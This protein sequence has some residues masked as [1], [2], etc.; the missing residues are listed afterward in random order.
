VLDG[1]PTVQSNSLQGYLDGALFGSG[2]GSQLWS[3]GDDIGIGQVAEYTKFHTGEASGAPSGLAGLI[4]EVRAYNRALSAAEIE[5][6]SHQSMGTIERL[7]VSLADS[8]IGEQSGSTIATVTRSG[9]T[10]ASL[11]V[12]L[13]SSDSSEATTPTSVTL[14]TGQASATFTIESVDDNVRDGSQAVTITAS[15][16]DM[17]GGCDALIVTDN[18]QLLVRGV[19]ANVTNQWTT[20]ALPQDYM[21]MVVV[22]TPS[23][24]ESSVPLVTRMR[25][26]GSNSF[27][28]RVDRTDGLADP[29]A[30]VSVHY[31]VTEEGVYTQE[32]DGIA[33]EAVKYAST[34]VDGRGNWVGEQRSFAQFYRTPVVLGQVQT[35]NDEAFTQFW[36]R[37]AHQDDPADSQELWVGRHV[38]EDVNVIRSPET[39]G[40]LV[41]EAGTASVDGL[42]F[43]ANVGSATIQGMENS[44]PFQYAING[45]SAA[46]V[47]VANV[48]G[49]YGDQGGWAVLYGADAV[50]ASSLKLAVDEDQAADAERRHVAENVSYLVFQDALLQAVGTPNR[51]AAPAEAT[52]DSLDALLE[53]AIM[54]WG[55]SPTEDHRADQWDLG[56][57]DLPGRQLASFAADRL[58]IDHDAAGHGWFVDDSPTDHAEFFRTFGNHHWVALD[59]GPAAGRVDLLTVLAHELGHADG[60]GHTYHDAQDIMS[61]TLPVG[62]RRLPY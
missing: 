9:D 44:P 61:E 3:H 35:Y 18:E 8:E 51:A 10:T 43:T 23:Y 14:A 11:L 15:A 58:W 49:M 32:R 7:T 52:L 5:V 30:G 60:I 56:I 21:S 17:S 62:V 48:S 22:A 20:V 39:V 12:T 24:T 31:V 1:G 25:N 40:Y 57:R 26:A 42:T 46:S 54:S 47:A 50:S 53:A 59:E 45:L 29:V 33:M 13:T 38:G 2:A 37:G 28:L 34:V 19:V 36:S 41:L 16:V 55:H 4:D 6:L 27:E